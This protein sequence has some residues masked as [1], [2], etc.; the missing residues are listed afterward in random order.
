[1]EPPLGG[2]GKWRPVRRRRYAGPWPQWSRP[3]VG[4]ERTS[5]TKHGHS[6]LSP[7]WSRPLVGAE[8]GRTAGALRGAP[9]RNGAAPWWERKGLYPCS[10]RPSSSSRNGAA[11]WWERKAPQ[12]APIDPVPDGMPQWSRP[13]VGAESPAEPVMPQSP[14][15]CRNGAAPWWERKG[16]DPTPK[17]AG[18]DT[19][20]MEPPLGGSGKLQLG[21]LGILEPVPAAME[22]PLGGSGKCRWG[23]HPSDSPPAAMEP[24]LGGSGKRRSPPTSAAASPPQWSRPLVGAERHHLQPVEP[25]RK[26]SPQWS[27][28][29]VGA[30][31]DTDETGQRVLHMPQWSRPLVGAERVRMVVRSTTSSQ[32]QWSRPL[33]GAE[34]APP[35]RSL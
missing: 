2:S 29:L 28:P 8:S 7:Q 20:A 35:G 3:L 21:A 19:A 5:G 24:P 30:E 33:V 13:L 31:R 17:V 11:P 26:A 18:N 27:R 22:P 23:C 14:S 1:M 12:S 9:G 4:A 6:V 32:P 16:T 15:Q 10:C 25:R 34:R